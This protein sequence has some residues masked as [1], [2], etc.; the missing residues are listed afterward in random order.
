MMENKAVEKTGRRISE[1]INN[2]SRENSAVIL[3][4][5]MLLIAVLFVPNFVSP[6][7]FMNIMRQADTLIIGSVAATFILMIGGMDFSIGYIVG[8]SS[9]VLGIL[10]VKMKAPSVIVIFITLA[11]GLMWGIINGLIIQYLSVP[12]FITT[13]GMGY[14]MYGILQ[15]LSNGVSLQGISEELLVIGTTSILGLPSSVYIAVLIAAICGVLF[16]LTIFG[17]KL[18]AIGLN[19]SASKISG[20][21]TNLLSTMVYGLSGLLAASA[22]IFMSLKVAASQPTMGGPDFTF[23]AIMGAV[24]GGASLFGGKGNI[25]GTVLGVFML[26]IINVCMVLLKIDANAETAVVGIIILV[27]VV[28]DSLRNKITS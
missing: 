17:R 9:V 28:I 11:V 6:N 22:G 5:I 8:F 23:R 21:K 2:F 27:V 14:V 20:L 1:K 12:P 24:L 16:H 19:L 18:K 15:I 3:F 13:L 26:T 10:D 25:L 7:V 4:V